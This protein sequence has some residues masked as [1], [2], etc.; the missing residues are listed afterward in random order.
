MNDWITLELSGKRGKLKS[1]S[2]LR[3]WSNMREVDGKVGRSNA[4]NEWLWYKHTPLFRT[5]FDGERF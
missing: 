2:D 3:K 5:A 1:L 4:E